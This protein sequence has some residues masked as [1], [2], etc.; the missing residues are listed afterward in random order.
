MEGKEL[1]LSSHHGTTFRL[2]NTIHTRKKWSEWEFGYYQPIDEQFEDKQS[3]IEETD[4]DGMVDSFWN[5]WKKLIGVIPANIV[6][7][8][9]KEARETLGALK[10]RGTSKSMGAK[11]EVPLKDAYDLYPITGVAK[12]FSCHFLPT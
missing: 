9:L 3:V 8:G 11:L 12:Q 6:F 4:D 1:K 10:T 2:A 5:R 7:D